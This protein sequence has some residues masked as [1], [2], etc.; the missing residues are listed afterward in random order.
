LFL[1]LISTQP[2]FF[3]SKKWLVEFLNFCPLIDTVS[4]GKFV[5]TFGLQ[6]ELVLK[7]ALG[8][9][10][11]LKDLSTLFIE[12]KT[13]AQIPY[14]IQTAKAKNHEEIFIKLE[15]ID[16][17][18][19]AQLITRKSIWLKREDFEKYA[20]PAAS[21]SLIGFTV[22]ENNKPLGEITEVIEQPHQVLCTVLIE[23]KEA[24]IPLHEG[25]LLK[26]DRKKKEVHVD[27]PEG[28][29]DIYLS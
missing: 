27:L 23:G 16:T 25:S 6:G 29:L 24:L 10:T 20:A 12:D 13:G 19:A 7:H 9:K 15:G 26:I 1:V 17:K 2:V 11:A 4:I 14:F 21:I 8:K 22:V 18:E 28:L 5:A 3:L